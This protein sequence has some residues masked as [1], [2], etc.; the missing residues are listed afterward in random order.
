LKW[1]VERLEGKAGAVDTPIGRTPE[2]ASLDTSGLQLSDEQLE[3]LLGV[4]AEVWKQEAAL[5][6]PDYARF[7]DTLPEALWAQHRALLERLER[8]P[9]KLVAAE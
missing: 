9:A 7:G 8:A 3:L 5:I 2:K 6:G 4:D 1:I